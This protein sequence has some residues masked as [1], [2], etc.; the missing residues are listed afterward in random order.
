MDNGDS[1]STNYYLYLISSLVITYFLF[2]R[3]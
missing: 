2:N 1:N 3:K